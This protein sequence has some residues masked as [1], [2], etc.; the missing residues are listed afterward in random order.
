MSPIPIQNALPFGRSV[1]ALCNR[2]MR[3]KKHSLKGLGARRL[4]QGLDHEP[5]IGIAEE[6]FFLVV[7]VTIEQDRLALRGK[8]GGK[9][10]ILSQDGVK[11]VHHG[12][13]WVGFEFLENGHG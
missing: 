6:G 1:S 10:I 5:V 13:Q 12:F 8:E 3:G 2:S 11:K 9:T 7:S 4:S